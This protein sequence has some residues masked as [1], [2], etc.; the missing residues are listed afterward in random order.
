M[1]VC[2]FAHLLIFCITFFLAYNNIDDEALM[3]WADFIAGSQRPCWYT[4][5]SRKHWKDG[6]GNL[7]F[8]ICFIDFLI[9]AL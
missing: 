9:G 4:G 7:F 6:M 2:E 8:L 1:K 3:L 5:S